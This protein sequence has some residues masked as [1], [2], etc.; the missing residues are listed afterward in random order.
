MAKAMR[1]GDREAVR[2][3][4][5]RRRTLPSQD[6]D[7]PGYRRLRYVR[8]CDDFLFGFAGPRREAE[9]I[10]S[11][12]RAF[13]RDELKLELSE[14]K[15]LITHAASQAARFL[16]YEIRAQHADTKITRNRRAVNGVIGLFV[17]RD[18]IRS[19]CAAYMKRGKP[20]LRGPLLHDEDFTIVAKYGAEYRG[21]V[22]YYLLAQDVFR[23]G[24]LR[25]VMETSMLK[26]LAAKHKSSVTKMARKYKAAIDTPDERTGFEVVVQRDR[27]RKPL[28]ARFGG[29]PLTRK[30]T[31]VIT[32]L[33]PTL[34]TVKGN[35]L[36]HRLLA[37]R[38]ELCESRVELQ[39]H[40]IRK[41]ADLDKPGRPERPGWVRLMA[42]RKRK[43]LVVYEACHRTSTPDGLQPPPGNENWRDQ[44]CEETR[45]HGSGKGPSEKDPHHG[46]LVGGLLH[47]VG[48]PAEMPRAT[49]P[50]KDAL[51]AIPCRLMSVVN[52][53]A[54]ITP[55]SHARI[56]G[57]RVA[58]AVG[59]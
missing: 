6:P 44:V 37:G 2:A 42:M 38:C 34:A 50:N 11:K 21:I 56:T 26:T 55:S 13:L 8:Y 35:E 46:H 5:L 27:G 48:A 31:A 39:V 58:P 32:D 40:H 59:R 15:T 47:S 57:R 49:R 28:V 22:Q 18:V 10:K 20:A 17:P 51:Q 23:L 12:V 25:W 24:R 45:Q 41:L 36:I 43:T 7:D 33:A 52:A 14:S 4:R 30:R 19:K 16:G 1:H 29:I 9:E 53:T 54:V 3:L